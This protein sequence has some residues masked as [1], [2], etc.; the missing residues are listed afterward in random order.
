MQHYSD[1]KKLTQHEKKLYNNSGMIKQSRNGKGRG[2]K[3]PHIVQ[4]FFNENEKEFIARRAFEAGV[5]DSTYIRQ[6]M[7]KGHWKAD[8]DALRES[9]PDVREFDARRR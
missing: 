7:I 5:S 6:R 9:Q 1:G 8:L 4:V 3:R 2:L